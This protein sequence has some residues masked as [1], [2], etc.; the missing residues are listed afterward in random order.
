MTVS[1]LPL[2]WGGPHRATYAVS[3]APATGIASAVINRILRSRIW[4]EVFAGSAATTSGYSGDA[5]DPDWNHA[6]PPLPAMKMRP[7]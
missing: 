1:A 3:R 4:R 2:E 5:V 6:W 7:V